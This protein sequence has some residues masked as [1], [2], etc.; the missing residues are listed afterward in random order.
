MLARV[1]CTRNPRLRTKIFWHNLTRLIKK[2]TDDKIF[3]RPLQELA[4]YRPY[5]RRLE[6]LTFADVITKAAFSL[7]LFKLKS[8]CVVGPGF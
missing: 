3:L 5:L 7:Q 8:L 4:F 6:S 1:I 2:N